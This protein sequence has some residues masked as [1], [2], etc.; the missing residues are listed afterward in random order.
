MLLLS[1]FANIN[2]RD[3]KIAAFDTDEPY[4]NFFK[5]VYGRVIIANSLMNA[6]EWT[7]DPITEEVLSNLNL[8]TNIIDLML[9]GIELLSDNHAVPEIEQ[10]QS[11]VRCLEVIPAVLYYNLSRSYTNYKRNSLSSQIV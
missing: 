4:L 5:E 2:T 3:Y 9:Y 6:Y 10:D 1:G 11:R 7:I 8:P